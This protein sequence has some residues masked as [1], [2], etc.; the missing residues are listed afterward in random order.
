MLYIQYSDVDDDDAVD[1]LAPPKPRGYT[2]H[3]YHLS[4]PYNGLRRRTDALTPAQILTL[5]I[6][7]IVYRGYYGYG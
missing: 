6:L 3:L 1:G 5:L 4:M 2:L 7:T